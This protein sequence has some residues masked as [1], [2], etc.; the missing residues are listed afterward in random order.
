MF[1]FFK[2]P[3]LHEVTYEKV[4]ANGEHITHSVFVAARSK[5]EAVK[6]AA[7]KLSLDVAKIKSVDVKVE[8][9]IFTFGEGVGK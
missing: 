3:E 6:V 1:S 9:P 8:L 5:A 2:K 7:K 4:F